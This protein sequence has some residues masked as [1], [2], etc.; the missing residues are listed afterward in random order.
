MELKGLTYAMGG[1]NLVQCIKY[2]NPSI[3]ITLVSDGD[4]KR[5]YRPEHYTPFDTIKEISLCDYIDKNGKFQPALAK[6][7][8]HKYSDYNHP[9]YIDADS[10]VIKD[11]QP[12]I[13]DLILADGNFYSHA[14]GSGIKSEEIECSPWVTNEQMWE[15]FSLPEDQKIITINTSWFYFNKKSESFFKKTL[16]NFNK[17]FKE[18]ELKMK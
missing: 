9:L 18:E 4:H 17:G 11:I 6:I 13:D 2:F 14:I 7:N 15:F 10:I 8:I 16:E 5:H 12:L 1:I 3:N